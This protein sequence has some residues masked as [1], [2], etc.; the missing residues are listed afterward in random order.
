MGK[1]KHTSGS[2]EDDALDDVFDEGEGSDDVDE[3]P[4][5]DKVLEGEDEDE[6]EEEG[7]N[8]EESDE[9][10]VVFDGYVLDEEPS[11]TTE[12]DYG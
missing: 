6:D 12:G 7:E 8:E 2:D 11:P 10:I 9:G 4:V 3:D 1:R 5:D